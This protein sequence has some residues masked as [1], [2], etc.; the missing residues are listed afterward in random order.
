MLQCM[1]EIKSGTQSHAAGERR[2]NFNMNNITTNMND[3]KNYVT[4]MASES[5]TGENISWICSSQKNSVVENLLCNYFK[6]VFSA[7]T[8][9]I[10][11]VVSLCYM[12]GDNLYDAT[13][14]PLKTETTKIKETRLKISRDDNRNACLVGMK[15]CAMTSSTDAL[16]FLKRY[17]NR[18]DKN[19]HLL[20]LVNIRNGKGLISKFQFWEL[21]WSEKGLQNEHCLT[22]LQNCVRVLRENDLKAKAGR[23]PMLVPYRDCVLTR[24]LQP[25][26]R[27]TKHQILFD[28]LLFDKQHMDHNAKFDIVQQT[29]SF[30]C[31]KSKLQSVEA[32]RSGSKR[33]SQKSMEEILPLR[34]QLLEDPL[35]ED[36][37]SNTPFDGRSID[38]QSEL[39][40]YNSDN[41]GYGEPSEPPPFSP[42]LVVKRVRGRKKVATGLKKINRV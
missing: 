12:R 3:F 37:K 15:E 42:K 34:G 24:L 2:W 19:D 39:H 1:L 40:E 26:I 25:Y 18:V 10:V 5:L 11:L 35:N 30:V 27:K 23:K 14:I 9:E 8:M 28:V 22:R 16:S 38:S 21:R 6:E 4:T 29:L 41:E 31:S 32:Y 20:L 36:R 13:E 33:R 7:A 17:R